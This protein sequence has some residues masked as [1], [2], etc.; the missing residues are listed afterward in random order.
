MKFS[1]FFTKTKKQMPVAEETPGAKL[2][3][4]AGFV[5]KLSAGLYNY[6]PLGLMTLK[7]IKKIIG[8]ELSKAGVIEILTPI[9]QPAS[10]WK[11]SGRFYSIGDELWKIK[12]QK[13]EDFILQLS[14]EEIFVDIARS[15]IQSYKDLPIIL[16]Q[17][18][19]KI[20]NELRPRA[21]LLRVREFLMQDAY[22]FDKDKNGLSES[23]DKMLKVYANIFKR[24]ELKAIPVDA[25]TGKMG[26]T[27][28]NEFILVNES[29]EDNVAICEKC[30]YAA[31]VEKA[32]CLITPER[33]EKKLEKEKVKTPHMISVDEVSEYLKTDNQHVLKSV[34]F[35]IIG[36]EKLVMAII[37]GDFDINQKKLENAIGG[38]EVKMLPE[39]EMESLDLIPG[40]I[41]P[42]N[43]ESIDIKILAD[44]SVKYMCNFIAGGNER[45]M[46]F[47]DANLEDMKIDEWVDLV[48]V[49]EG[50]RCKKC[51][52]VLKIEKAIELAHT[53]KPGTW[54]SK[55]MNLKFTD[56]DG[57][58]KLVYMGSYGIGLGRLMS[59]IAE[60][61]HDE[62]GLIWPK[63][64]APFQIYLIN[65]SDLSDSKEL[66]EKIYKELIE[67]GFHVLYD[68]REVSTGVKFA[69]TDLIGIPIR[70][71]LS[72]K[73]IA[74]NSVEI[75][76]RDSKK[77]EL[78]EI[79]NLSKEL[80]R[81]CDN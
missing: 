5:S 51:G 2:L 63:S 46:H 6:L 13:D 53:F 45:D 32:E 54:Y 16:N 55:S 24:L 33:P 26:G 80:R 67:S 73:T 43:L 29:G 64:V 31:N 38:K 50:A 35:K 40:F 7:K 41:S 21:G 23:Y 57:K 52:S 72:Q 58:E 78:I 12:N 10:Y 27:E 8:E 28:S 74:K 62:N 14:S 56:K 68:D 15:N 75:K 11:E 76:M 19:T 3:V 36:T 34:L 37:R 18:Q 61:S 17:F 47:K 44:T 70:I 4:Q 77:T 49:G 66:I 39:K 48:K 22:S 79:K 60:N 42:I 1:E 59:A 71:V 69:D 30:D 25:D 65:L 9:I 20:R 81:I